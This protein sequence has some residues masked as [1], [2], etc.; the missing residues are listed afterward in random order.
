MVF[1][2][3]SLGPTRLGSRIVNIDDS[4][5]EEISGYIKTLPLA[6]GGMPGAMA[7]TDVALVVANSFPAAMRAEQLVD[8]KWDVPPEQLLNSED[9]MTDAKTLQKERLEVNFL[10][11]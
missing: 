7:P 3:V 10:C 8:I 6:A 9:L 2:K 4:E 1:G 11:W 5:A